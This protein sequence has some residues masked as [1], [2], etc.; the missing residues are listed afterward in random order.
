MGSTV[1]ARR[2]DGR[3]ATS[4]TAS[5]VAAATAQANDSMPPSG[6]HDGSEVRTQKAAERDPDANLP[7]ARLDHAASPESA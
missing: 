1:A 2:A 7:G 6:Y 5:V 3:P 4:A